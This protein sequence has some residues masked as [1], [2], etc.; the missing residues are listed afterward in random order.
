MHLT[1]II[2]LVLSIRYILNDYNMFSDV[3]ACSPTLTKYGLKC[4]N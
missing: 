3:W 2:M 1:Y 4:S